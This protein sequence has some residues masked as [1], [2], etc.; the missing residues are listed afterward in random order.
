MGAGIGYYVID[1]LKLGIN[2]QFWLGG[3]IS[4]NK[5]S[6]QFQYVFARDEKLKPYIGA[7]YRK[8]SVEGLQDLDS[9]GF[10]A[11]VFL[12]SRGGHYMGFGLVHETYNRC[13]K[14]VLL[15]CSDTYPELIFTFVL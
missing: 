10:R 4:I 5:I 3:D 15:S 6:P 2:A 13:D 7:F 12:S 14:T 8:T 9:S 11:G 1:G